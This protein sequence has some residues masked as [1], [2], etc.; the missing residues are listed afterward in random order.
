MSTL[1][2]SLKAVVT[3]HSIKDRIRTAYGYLNRLKHL[4]EDVSNMCYVGKIL[5]ESINTTLMGLFY[6]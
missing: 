5:M 1:T 4:C 3:K 2:K 6:F